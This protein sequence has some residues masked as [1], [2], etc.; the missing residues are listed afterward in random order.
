[1]AIVCT[2]RKDQP[3]RLLLNLLFYHFN[4]SEPTHKSQ[5]IKL[6]D[7]IA[8]YNRLNVNPLNLIMTTI[9][10]I[11]LKLNFRLQAISVFRATHHSNIFLIFLWKLYTMQCVLSII[12]F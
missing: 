12:Q 9:F 1:M 4:H 2:L 7:V 10:S 8:A 3:P 5:C 11:L 6:L